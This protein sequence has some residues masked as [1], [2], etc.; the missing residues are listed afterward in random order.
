MKLEIMK[1]EISYE[2]TILDRLNILVFS[3]LTKLHEQYKLQQV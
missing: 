2:I 1:V 3:K